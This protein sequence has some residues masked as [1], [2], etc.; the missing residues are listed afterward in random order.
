MPETL[1]SFCLVL[2]GHLPYVLRH[3]TWPHGEDWLFEAAAETYLPL[4][5]MVE[6]C[7]FFNAVPKLTV[8]LTP[9]LLE[10]LAHEHFKKGFEHYL[11]DR[12]QRAREDRADFE[13]SHD[14]HL[15]YLA[16]RWE[17]TYTKLL[18][19]F[20]DIGRD[21]PKAFAKLADKGYLEILTSNATHG[22]MPLL[23][24]DSALRAQM[25][26]GIASSERILGFRPKGMWLPECAYRPSGTWHPPIAWGQPHVRP[27]IEHIVADEGIR[28]FFV[29]SHLVTESRSEQAFN[30]GLW[31]KVGWDEAGKYPNR[32]W[33]SVNEAHGVNSDGNGL[34]R[35]WVLAR[36]Q[37]A[38]EKV[39]SGTIGY[40]ADGAYLEFHKTHGRTRG[41]RY[42]KITGNK[43]DLGDKHY[44]YPDDIPG[45][46]HEHVAHFCNV[47]KE[48][49]KHHRDT[50]GRNNGVV[51]CTFD[52]E[53]FGH[54]WSEGVRFIR[55]VMLTLHSDPQVQLRTSNE[56]LDSTF[57]DKVVALPEGSWG[58]AG[59]HRVWTNDQVN[60]MWEIEYRCESTFG[61]L[62][63]ELDWRKNAAVRDL[64]EKAG[65]ELLLLQASDWPFV[66]KRGQAIDYGIKRF[67]QHVA[68]FDVLTDLANKV[69]SNN[70]YL[71]SLTDI[72]RHE[73]TDA[74]IHDVI[75][76]KIDLNWWNA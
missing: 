69:A 43:V 24:T 76:P 20:E 29:E 60:W 22:Y 16:E 72:E 11:N 52:A 63:Y 28:H 38:C 17:Q 50:T 13:K 27:G 55:D 64:L 35:A 48:R 2:H 46:L 51:V 73:I 33:R 61:R 31:T 58:E 25:R 45:K 7:V 47:I 21:I 26:A 32:G 3:G 10:Q 36:D 1:G 14:G 39:W 70:K 19:Q 23:L 62:T 75:F 56:Y 30:E 42:W 44:Y 57:C 12:A 5:A 6:E 59:D 4:L 74:E 71:G 66:I 40:P 34:A 41:L 54:W 67:I 68:R 37:A 53:L 49:L 8:G 65:R 18:A 9:V 15:A